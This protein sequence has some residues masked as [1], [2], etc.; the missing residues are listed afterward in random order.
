MLIA[1]TERERDIRFR[2]PVYPVLLHWSRKV[3][4]PHGVGGGAP[5]SACPGRFPKDYETYFDL[6]FSTGRAWRRSN[7]TRRS[8]PGFI[9]SLHW[10]TALWEVTG[11][12]IA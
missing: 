7:R 6:V 5:P 1:L 8:S 4:A 9:G 11:L 10:K 12:C 3:Y 2:R